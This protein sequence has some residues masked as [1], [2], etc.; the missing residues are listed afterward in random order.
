MSLGSC[1]KC[2]DN[3]CTCGHEYIDR[4]QSND[5]KIKIIAAILEISENDSLLDDIKYFLKVARS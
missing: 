2:W 4:N 5:H 1:A 3:P